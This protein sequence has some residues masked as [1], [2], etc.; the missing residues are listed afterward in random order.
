MTSESDE[1]LA[2]FTVTTG[3]ISRRSDISLQTVKHYAA[4]NLLGP[5]VTLDSGIKLYT[6]RSVEL[7]LKVYN[8]RAARGGRPL[9]TLPST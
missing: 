8:E 9:K 3:A 2:H 1:L 4:A 7:A 6:E 5:V